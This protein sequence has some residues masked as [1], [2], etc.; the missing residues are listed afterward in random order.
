MDQEMPR[1]AELPSCDGSERVP[2]QEEQVAPRT[3]RGRPAPEA[4]KVNIELVVV[5][6]EEG[7]ELLKRQAAA[8]RDALG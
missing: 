6:G 8:V 1:P 4:P 2:V 3:K 7:K 5:E